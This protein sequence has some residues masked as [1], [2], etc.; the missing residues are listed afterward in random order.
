MLSFW[1]LMSERDGTASRCNYQSTKRKPIVNAPAEVKCATAFHEFFLCCTRFLYTLH[2]PAR[3]LGLQTIFASG[4][5][6]PPRR[7]LH[8]QMPS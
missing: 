3:A 1:C 4:P 6:L 5:T 2:E 7:P 8:C